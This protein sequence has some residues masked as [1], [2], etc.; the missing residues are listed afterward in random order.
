M[1]TVIFCP[2]SNQFSHNCRTVEVT[3]IEYL[4]LLNNCTQSRIN[5]TLSLKQNNPRLSFIKDRLFAFHG[6]LIIKHFS[7]Q[8]VKTNA[9][10]T[11]TNLNL[12]WHNFS[13]K[14]K[15]RFLESLCQESEI[16][17]WGRWSPLYWHKSKRK[18]ILKGARGKSVRSSGEEKHPHQ[19]S[20]LFESDQWKW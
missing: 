12:T 9:K 13:L 3:E 4:C 20:F 19:T 8:D 6:F 7:P 2:P 18:E 16:R 14:N 15:K 5:D 17:P 10:N 1:K 11:W